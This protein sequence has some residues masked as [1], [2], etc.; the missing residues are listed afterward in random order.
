M[1]VFRATEH[2]GDK[3]LSVSWLGVSSFYGYP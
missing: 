3:K 2:M 1:V